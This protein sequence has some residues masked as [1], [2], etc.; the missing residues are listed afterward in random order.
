MKIEMKKSSIILLSLFISIAAFSQKSPGLALT[1]PMGW[2]SW[3]TFRTDINEK[4]VM[5]IAD[6]FVK[7]NLKDAG[8]E[9]IV[10]DDGWMARERDADLKLVPDPKKFPNGM[11]AVVDYVHSKGLKFGIYNCAGATTCAG[12]P[13]SRGFEFQ[14]AKQY[15]E[16]GVDF[17]KYDW[18]DTKNINPIGAYETMR[19]AIAA[20]GRPMIFSI[21]EWGDNDPWLWA[22]EMGHM[23]RVTGD[24][25]NCWNCELS[26]GS[27]SSWGIWPIINMRQDIRKYSGPGH[28]N[29]FDM[30]EVGNGFSP[31]EDRVHFAMWCMLSSPLILGNDVRTMN[32]E[33]QKLLTNKEIIAINQDELGIQ[34]YRHIN[35]GN[36]EVWAKPL[37]NGEW[38]IAFVNMRETE[39]ILNFD[40][41]QHPI[42]DQMVSRTIELEKHQY[43]LRDVI[44]HKDAGTTAKKISQKVA[45]HDL[46]LFRLKPLK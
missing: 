37:A 12:Y 22:E 34:G 1:P 41:N 27:F 16:W 35:D 5:E 17:L 8:Y 42:S 13:G 30:M 9:Y 6:A 38:A 28:W 4:L 18:C 23:W 26:Y 33:T 11:K 29:D 40:W 24:I 44:A 36:F 7:Y 15:A 20:T 31:S 25:I 3:N 45:G 19:N 46:L 21:C 39:Q 43:S 10:L 2:N 32:Q 14:D